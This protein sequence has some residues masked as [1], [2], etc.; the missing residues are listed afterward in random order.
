MDGPTTNHKSQANLIEIWSISEPAASGSARL[1]LPNLC[2]RVGD[3]VVSIT[4]V[5]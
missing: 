3:F 4:A 2:H 1:T 5:I